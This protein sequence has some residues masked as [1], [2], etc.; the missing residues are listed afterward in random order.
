MRVSVVASVALSATFSCLL[1]PSSSSAIVSSEVTPQSRVSAQ[2]PAVLPSGLDTL[3]EY[4]ARRAAAFTGI[5]INQQLRVIHIGIAPG[6]PR[7]VVTSVSAIARNLALLQGNRST[8]WTIQFSRAQYSEADLQRTMGLI[9][10]PRSGSWFKLSEALLTSWYI[11]FSSDRVVVGLTRLTPQ[12]QKAARASFGRI[13]DLVAM[14]RPSMLVYHRSLTKKPT[15]VFVRPGHRQPGSISSRCSCSRLLD[16]TP[17]WGGDRLIWSNGKVIVQCTQAFPWTPKGRQ[18]TFD[19]SVT[20]GHCGPTRRV[21]QQGYYNQSKKKVFVTGKAG[22]DTLT[23]FGNNKIDGEVLSDADMTI[24]VYDTPKV[25][26]PGA[27]IVGYKAPIQGQKVCA[28]GSFTY[29]RCG[30]VVRSTHV[31]VK[32]NDNGTVVR[33][34]GLVYSTARKR[35]AQPGDSGGPV[36]SFKRTKPI[37]EVIIAGIIDIGNGPGTKLWFVNVS[38][39]DRALKGHPTT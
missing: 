22:K 10:S 13:V 32:A 29:Q 18:P 24:I 23:S 34:C 39:L 35:L 11:S 21:W 38:F 7:S 5:W 1:A 8:A 27:T 12:L 28:D 2:N 3:Q 25:A 37:P 17:Y 9:D 16:N 19:K 15:V 20:A 31:C 4:V 26:G 30:A 36:Y 6:V 33:T 14:S